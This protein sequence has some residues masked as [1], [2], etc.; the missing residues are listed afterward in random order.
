MTGS[1]SELGA[2]LFVL[3]CRAPR[4]AAVDKVVVAPRNSSTCNLQLL[5]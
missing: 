5:H 4:A 1:A 3:K 2:L